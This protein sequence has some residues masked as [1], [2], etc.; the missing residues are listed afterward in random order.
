MLSHRLFVENDDVIAGLNMYST[1]PSAFDDSAEIMSTVLATH[2][3]VTLSAALAREQAEQLRAALISNREIGIAMGVLMHSHKVTRDQAFDL[4]RIGSQRQN[5]KLADVAAEVAETG[6]LHV[7][8]RPAKPR[9]SRRS[10]TSTR[11]AAATPGS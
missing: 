3:A 6:D 9:R 4:L 5:R 10:T 8:A 1:K 11:A 2:A 7:Q